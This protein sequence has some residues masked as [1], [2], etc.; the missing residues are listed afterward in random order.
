MSVFCRSLCTTEAN[1]VVVKSNR[2][3]RALTPQAFMVEQWGANGT[4]KAPN[5]S[6]LSLWH[7]FVCRLLGR[8][9]LS[10]VLL[11]AEEHRV[12]CCNLVAFLIF[13]IPAKL[14]FLS[15]NEVKWC[16]SM[17]YKAYDYSNCS[18]ILFPS[19]ACS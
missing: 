5:H 6:L 11:G 16:P 17:Q 4:L 13:S 7:A 18:Y 3:T 10:T 15:A 8:I 1:T 2:R 14:M 9:C 19:L 12:Q